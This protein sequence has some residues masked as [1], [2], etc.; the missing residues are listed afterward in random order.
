MPEV[1]SID[2]P[3]PA[4]WPEFQKYVPHILTLR[5]HC[6][7]PEPP[8]VLSVNFA[9]VLSNMATFM[10]H[11]G[12]LADGIDAMRTAEGILEAHHI[13]NEDPLRSNIHQHIAIIASHGGV[14][15]RDEAMSRRHTAIESRNISHGIIAARG[16]VTRE[17]EIRLWNVQSDMAYGLLQCEEFAQ[18][19]VIIER[20]RDQYKIW[21]DSK[22]IPFE[23]LKYCHIICYTYMAEG[24]ALEA[25]KAGKEGVR[26]GEVC[27]GVLHSY[28]LHV[29]CS[30]ANLLYFAGMIDESLMENLTVLQGRITM[31][32]E[33]NHYTIE[34][35]VMC[36]ALY[37]KLD[38]LEK[39]E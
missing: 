32:G 11:A 5:A 25:I 18:S 33:F 22:A 4:L 3:E 31:M 7:W 16:A 15:M 36:G 30:L 37:A 21:G 6:L 29:R 1:S 8:M 2:N 28:T 24:K 12:L 27:G 10:W 9:W 13:G 38:N 35:H 34:S 26:L 19:G 39:A 23:Y 17:D 20:C 14:S